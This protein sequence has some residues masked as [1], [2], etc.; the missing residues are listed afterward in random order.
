MRVFQ[1]TSRGLFECGL[2]IRKFAGPHTM[3]CKFYLSILAEYFA[4][5]DNF[6][7]SYAR[8]HP[9]Q[10]LSLGHTRRNGSHNFMPSLQSM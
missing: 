10:L 9:Q 6:S 2:T 8:M 1:V 3:E 5:G 7:T 4:I